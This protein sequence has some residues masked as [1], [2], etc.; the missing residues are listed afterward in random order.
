MT[1]AQLQRDFQSFLVSASAD[2]A[3]RLSVNSGSCPDCGASPGLAVYQNNYRAQLVGCLE[4]SFPQVR[5]WIGADAFLAAAIEHID[6]HPPHSWTLDAYAVDFHRTLN[7]HFPDNP[8][9]HELAWIEQAL[10]EAFVAPDAAPLA[11]DALAAVDWDSVR[12]RLAPSLASH[13]ATTNAEQIWSALWQQEAVPE[14][15]MLEQ[16]GGLLVWRRGYQ[17]CLKQVDLLEYQALL[18]L[19]QDGSFAALCDWLVERLGDEA[20]IARAGAL[21]AGWLAGELIT[22]IA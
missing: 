6:T 11:L 19:R 21:L 20:G 22:G 9:V 5:G 8:D 4:A 14:S 15:A 13:A 12:L 16:P 2:A 18:Q 10:A 7:A 1:L 17:S 3:Q